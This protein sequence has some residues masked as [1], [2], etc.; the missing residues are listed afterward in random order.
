M[1][2]V[3][4]A[5]FRDALLASAQVQDSNGQPAGQVAVVHTSHAGHP[6]KVDITLTSNDGGHA[7]TISVSASK[8]RYDRDN[9]TLIADMT[10]SDLQSM[11]A[12]S[13]T[14]GM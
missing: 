8:L 2:R 9:N 13:S 5:G 11:P 10:L 12:V 14:A 4:N 3:R 7:K 1:L 6:T